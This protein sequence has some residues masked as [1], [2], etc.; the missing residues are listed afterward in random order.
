MNSLR[1]A[2]KF[3]WTEDMDADFKE[4]RL[5]FQIGRVQGYPDFHSDEPFRL[6]TDWGSKNIAGIL[7]QIQ[8]G[9]ERFLGCWGR[10]CIKSTPYPDTT[11]QP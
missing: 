11:I 8:E 5:E 3:V 2:E 9:E 1:K 4:L 7:S 10:K 6:T